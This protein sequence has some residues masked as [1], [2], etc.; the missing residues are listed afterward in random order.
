MASSL[1]TLDVS[2]RAEWRKWLKKHHTTKNNIW[3]IFHKRHTG[4]TSIPYNDAVEEA[5]CFGWI[6][7]LIKRLDDDKYVR[8][9]TPRKK[10][11]KW[12]TVNRRRYSKMR[13]AGLLEKQGL[14]R[15]PTKYDGDAPKL[16]V[17]K[18]PT[19][20]EEFLKPNKRAWEFFN[21]LAPSYRRMYIGWISSAKRKE[22][23]DK[24]LAEAR[25]LLAQGKKLGL[26]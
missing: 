3:L 2:N 8:L 17:N 9:F 24:R 23:R 10:E 22:T 21:T 15:P 14:K 19:Y 20:I 18:V 12:S 1:I 25:K 13:S 4:R 7:S 6:D 11:S 16:N 26:K 5:L